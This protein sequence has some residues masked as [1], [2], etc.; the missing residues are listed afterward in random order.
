MV[1]ELVELQKCWK[2]DN[3]KT[4]ILTKALELCT[5]LTASPEIMAHLENVGYHSFFSD[6][7]FKTTRY[8][9]DFALSFQFTLKAFRWSRD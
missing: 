6:V 3:H 8:K 4:A 7:V 9:N 1:L 2:E 5:V